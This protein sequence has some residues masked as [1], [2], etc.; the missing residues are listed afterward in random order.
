[1]QYGILQ[2]YT[3]AWVAEA[4]MKSDWGE[5]GKSDAEDRM[6]QSIGLQRAG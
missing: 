1:M 6:R 2:A 5:A 3:D 4:D